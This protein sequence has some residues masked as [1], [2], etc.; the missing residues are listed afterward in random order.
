MH[1]PSL[2]KIRRAL[3]SVSDKT[4][5]IEFARALAR[6]SIEILSTGGTSGLLRE[7]GVAVTDVSDETGFPELLDGRLKTLHPKIHGG[8]LGVRENE[9]HL[10]QM[11]EHAIKPIDLVVV[12][13]YPFERT[14]AKPGVE[15]VASRHL[16]GESH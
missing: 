16:V 4:G 13:L 15:R 1:D 12:N 11:T 8:I 5:I 3:V 2:R 10:R 9:N 7:S 6:H 14:V